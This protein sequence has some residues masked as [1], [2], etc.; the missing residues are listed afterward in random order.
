MAFDVSSVAMFYVQFSLIRK[1]IILYFL[2]RRA[3]MLLIVFLITE[4]HISTWIKL[5]RETGVLTAVCWQRD[6]LDEEMKT[7]FLVALLCADNWI[8]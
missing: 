5:F 1:L 4:V 3:L 8:T 6:R 2:C 7:F